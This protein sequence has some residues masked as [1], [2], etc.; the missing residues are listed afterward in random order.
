MRKTLGM[1][2]L[3]MAAAVLTGCGGGPGGTGGPANATT[4]A[5]QGGAKDLPA[6]G[7]DFDRVCE[8]QVGFADAT[9]YKAGAGLH[10]VALFEDH[11]DPPSLIETSRTLPAG[12]EVE[13]DADY[14]NNSEYAAVQLVACSRLVD[15]KANGTCEFEGDDGAPPTVLEKTDTTY[16]LT[17]YAAN[18]GTVVSAAQ[19]LV[20][21]PADCPMF[22]FIGEGD[23]KWFN[24]PTDEQYI[25]ALKGLVNPA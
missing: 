25:N 16:E 17:V 6:Y 24:K 22:L 19:T 15:A 1:I 23:T 3:A 14:V 10:P 5:T 20:A 12:W 8:T 9:A 4:G 13:G 2:G 7:G 21:P 11:G 18:N